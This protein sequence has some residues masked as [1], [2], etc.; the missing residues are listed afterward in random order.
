MRARRCCSDPEPRGLGLGLGASPGEP[1]ATE[2]PCLQLEVWTQPWRTTPYPASSNSRIS[3]ISIPRYSTSAGPGLSR[4][5]GSKDGQ[6]RLRVH[7]D[8]EPQCSRDG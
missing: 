1:R 7:P 2:R 4:E 3:S 8:P 5:L 6:V